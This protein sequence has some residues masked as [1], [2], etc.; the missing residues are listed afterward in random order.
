MRNAML[1]RVALVLFGLLAVPGAARAQDLV[2]NAEQ[3]TQQPRLVSA[4]RTAD[5]LRQAGRCMAGTVRLELVIGADGKVEPESVKTV[6]STND[7]L[8]AAAER[9]AVR[10]EFRPGEKDGR[11]VRT[12]VL[13]PLAFQP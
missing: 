8:T 4:S 11:P 7:G 1:G 5:M 13:L 10:I 2:F 12:R 9:V 3:L 6:H